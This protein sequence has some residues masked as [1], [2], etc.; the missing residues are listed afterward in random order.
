MERRGTLEVAAV[1]VFYLM[2]GDRKGR[3]VCR[4]S[5]E[6]EGTVS[7]L[8]EVVAVMKLMTLVVVIVKFSGQEGLVRPVCCM[9]S[10]AASESS[11][12]LHESI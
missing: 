10:G 1:V 8:A 3:T 2:N 6:R 7:G 11:L 4:D 5:V 12:L 9:W